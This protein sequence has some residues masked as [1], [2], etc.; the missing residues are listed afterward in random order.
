MPLP[1][2]LIGA[3]VAAGTGVGV[4][5]HGAV[6]MVKAKDKLK[7]AQIQNDANF[8]KLEHKNKSACNAMDILGENE[9]RI[10]EEFKYFADLFEK[11]HNRPS[12]ASI[13]IGNNIIPKF[14]PSDIEKASIG[15]SLL[16]SGIAGSALGSVGGFAASGATTA[17]VMAL[18][19]ASTGTAIS[20]L[21][22]AAATNATLAAIGGGPIVAGGG[23]IAL[24]TSILGEA[25][26]GVGLLVGG[27]IFSI[28]GSNLSGKADKAY[29]QMLENGKKINNICSYLGELQKSAQKYNNILMRVKTL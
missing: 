13:R 7:E 3:A 12:F 29:E 16:I 1:L 6:K 28:T 8:Q 19:S 11:I 23:G 27:S 20:T 10:L 21:S 18:G 22:G 9:L 5:I 15:A 2:L 4:G 24:G 26:L 25:T 17:A 14:S